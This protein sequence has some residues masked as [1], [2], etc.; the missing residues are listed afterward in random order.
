MPNDRV[1]LGNYKVRVQTGKIIS[2]QFALNP[3]DLLLMELAPIY[4][5]GGPGEWLDFRRVLFAEEL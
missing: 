4:K 3:S 1:S 2:K 5:L